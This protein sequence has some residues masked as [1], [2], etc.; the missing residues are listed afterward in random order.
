MDIAGKKGGMI[1][2]HKEQSVFAFVAVEAFSQ[3]LL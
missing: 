3:R 1:K 2:W